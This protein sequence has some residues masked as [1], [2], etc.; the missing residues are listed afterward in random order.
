MWNGKWLVP[1]QSK[2][3]SSVFACTLVLILYQLGPLCGLYILCNIMGHFAMTLVQ[4]QWWMQDV[5]ECWAWSHCGKRGK[6]RSTSWKIVKNDFLVNREL[7][8]E[9]FPL[10]TATHWVKCRGVKPEDQVWTLILIRASALCM[11]P[12]CMCEMSP[13]INGKDSCPW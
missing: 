11:E 3:A 6:G 10:D 8:A 9:W 5:E 7:R 12:Q 13:L 2:L 4:Y 1:S